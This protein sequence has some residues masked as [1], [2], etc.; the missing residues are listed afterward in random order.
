[1]LFLYRQDIAEQKFVKFALSLGCLLVCGAS[2]AQ[3][4]ISTG[5][6]K[7]EVEESVKLKSRVS[8]N[9]GVKM[10][11][12]AWSSWVT[13]PKGTGVALGAS[14]YQTVQAVG[15]SPQWSSI[16]FVNLRV[17]DFFISSSAMAPT[18]YNLRDAATPGGFDFPAS[19]KEFDINTGYYVLRGLAV[20]AGRKELQQTYGPDTFRWH[21]ILLGLN[22]SAPLSKGWAMY[23]NMAIGNMK[24]TFPGSQADIEGHTS[25]RT[26]YRLGEFGL[27]YIPP[28]IGKFS[29]PVL[30]TIGYRAQYASTQDYMLAVTDIAGN[31]RPN[32]STSLN[33]TTQGLVCSV[34]VNF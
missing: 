12:T 3:L 8:V 4:T 29:T 14:R 2:H 18:K 23:G 1:M 20:Y 27:A 19:R 21:G 34:I 6:A 9:A 16:P 28:W 10:W 15:S 25:F 11:S 26:T 5:K 30:L 32:T 17:N 22:G 24:A 31:S 7:E 33:D 13:A